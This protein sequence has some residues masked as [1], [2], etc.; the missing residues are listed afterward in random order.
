MRVAELSGNEKT[1]S[2]DGL[3]T[4]RVMIRLALVRVADLSDDD[5]TSSFACS[6]PVG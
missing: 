3:A 6:R 4:C 5:K 2:C 1:R